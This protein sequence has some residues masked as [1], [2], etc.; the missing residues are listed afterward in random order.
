[1]K[2]F[3]AYLAVQRRALALWVGTVALFWLVAVLYA[4][5][6]EPFA[7]ATVLSALLGGAVL[8]GGFARYRGRCRAVAECRRSITEACPSLPEPPGGEAGLEGEYQATLRALATARAV[9]ENEARVG[10][11]DI[12]DYFTIWVHQIKTPL[13]AMRLLLQAQPELPCR[14][15]LEGEL[16]KT[17]QYVGMV[18]GY[19]RLGEGGSDLVLARLPLDGIIRGAVRKFARLF[20]LKKLSL[21]YAGC[22]DS[23]V[24]DEKWLGFIL[25][26]LLSNAVKYTPVGGCVTV[27]ANAREVAVRDT[28]IG[29]RAED[30]PRIFEK[31]YTGANGRLEPH[32][33]G[34]GLY[35]CAA[36]A[37]KT[38]CTI[39]ASAAPGQGTAITVRFPKA[40]E[41]E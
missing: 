21:V 23:A 19:L 39:Q 10:R 28:G 4:L 8:A 15:E 1:M 33:T 7:Y 3:Y 26:Q 17:E 22:A 13:A 40:G 25:E 20:L 30:L 24:C 36:A 35:L 32:A 41:Y 14:A 38:G 6:A 34:L 31:G 29:I 12:L 2:C 27:T 37:R 9:L 11:D 5:P 18:L 16:F